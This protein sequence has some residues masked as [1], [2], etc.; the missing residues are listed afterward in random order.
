MAHPSIHNAAIL[1]AEI[2]TDCSWI[3]PILSYLRNW[4]LPEDKSEVVKVEARAARYTL[5]N[6]SLYRRSF[7]SHTRG[8]CHS[9]RQNISLNKFM[10][11]FVEPILANN[12]YDIGFYDI[13]FLLALMK[14]ESKLFVKNYD[15]YQK[16]DNI[17]HAPATTFHFVSSPWPFY[18]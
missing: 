13:G 12:H 18:K 5:I 3:S 9:M 7:S 1:T 10:K 6:D 11:E 14:Q 4:I 16:F 8:T 15:T 2:Q 17:I